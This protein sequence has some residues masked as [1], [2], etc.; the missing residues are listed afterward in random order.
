M[1]RLAHQAGM[2][3]RNFA[4]T[5]VQ[6]TNLTPADFVELA[7][8]DEARRL[9]EE[10]KAPLQRVARDSGFSGTQAMR[11]AFCRR[12]DVTPSEYRDRFRTTGDN[13]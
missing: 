9:L 7:R 11:R 1:A 4:R 8:I 10:T 13:S 3:E 6:E 5:F 12:L 2:S